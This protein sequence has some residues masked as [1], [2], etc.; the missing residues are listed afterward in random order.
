[1]ESFQVYL[2]GQALSYALVK[3]GFEPLHGT[4]IDTHGEATAFLGSSGYGKSSLAACFLA[5][6]HELLTDDLLLLKP[7]S[8][9]LEAYPGP[10]RIKLFPRVARRFL[11]K[12]DGI[13][14]N[15]FTQKKVIP[16]D[17]SR[18][19]PLPLRAI[20]CIA[21]PRE[22]R[23]TRKIEIT[24]LS[25]REAFV[26]LVKHTFNY[27]LVDPS[28]LQRQVRETARL[29]KSIP[30]QK[31]S[32]PRDL[33]QLPAVREAILADVEALRDRARQTELS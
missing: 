12:R 31:L 2:L 19:C 10:A 4:A 7:G 9:G 23:C 20:Y 16:F 27:V 30:I 13:P 22:N 29:V 14:M 5:A 11:P 6:G 32:Y 1:M 28:R 3:S 17:Q 26:L 33:D 25:A 8:R 18:A 21:P 15:L 24:P